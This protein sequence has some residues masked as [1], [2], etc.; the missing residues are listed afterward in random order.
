MRCRQELCATPPKK[1][2]FSQTEFILLP[3]ALTAPEPSQFRYRL[4]SRMVV[5]G[6]RTPAA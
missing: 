2:V 5:I 1:I 3:M 4:A 6:N